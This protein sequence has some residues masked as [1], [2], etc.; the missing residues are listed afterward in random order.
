MVTYGKGA[1]KD[2]IKEW[3]ACFVFKP[4]AARGS[5]GVMLTELIGIASFEEMMR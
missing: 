3:Q 2:I 5:N 4:V 1:N